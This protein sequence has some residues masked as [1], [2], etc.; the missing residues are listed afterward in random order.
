MVV[1]D[2][3]K[4]DQS[5][6]LFLALH[7]IYNYMNTWYLIARGKASGV[8]TS[9]FGLFLACVNEDNISKQTITSHLGQA[10]M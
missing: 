5:V 6:K 8:S 10:D 4:S 2:C 1:D 3:A 9:M 7:N